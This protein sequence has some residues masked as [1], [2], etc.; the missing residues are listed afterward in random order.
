MLIMASARLEDDLPAGCRAQRVCG[1]LQGCGRGHVPDRGAGLVAALRGGQAGAMGHVVPG[2]AGRPMAWRAVQGG[3]QACHLSDSCLAVTG[4]A[5]RG[6]QQAWAT[7]QAVERSWEPE[8][9]LCARCTHRDSVWQSAHKFPWHVRAAIASSHL[10][11]T[12]PLQALRRS[13]VQSCEPLHVK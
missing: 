3:R 2:M 10:P 11:G 9:S 5:G 12:R 13:T 8:V 4:F 1:W 6:T 7:Q